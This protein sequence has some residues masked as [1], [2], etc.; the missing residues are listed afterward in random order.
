MRGNW[1]LKMVFFAVVSSDDLMQAV[2]SSDDLMQLQVSHLYNMRNSREKKDL[3]RK[4][5]VQ[6]RI[7]NTR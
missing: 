6:L 5:L 2:V 4:I 1:Y 3:T 7:V